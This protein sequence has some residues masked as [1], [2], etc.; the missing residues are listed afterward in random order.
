MITALCIESAE[1]RFLAV[2]R[3]L[4]CTLS[5]VVKAQKK[6]RKN[7]FEQEAGTLSK[8]MPHESL[9]ENSLIHSSYIKCL[10]ARY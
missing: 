6:F 8:A 3:V 2:S 9:N 5:I 1:T 10:C 4:C 7:L